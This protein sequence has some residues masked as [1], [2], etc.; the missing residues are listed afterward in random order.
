M[1]FYGM[2]SVKR[3]KAIDWKEFAQNYIVC[4]AMVFDGLVTVCSL[5]LLTSDLRCYFLFDL[6]DK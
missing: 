2:F 5:G 3:C 1:D 6:F 4:L